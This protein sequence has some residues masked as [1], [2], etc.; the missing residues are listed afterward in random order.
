MGNKKKQKDKTHSK[1]VPNNFLSSFLG[2]F[3]LSVEKTLKKLP[4]SSQ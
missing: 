1:S 3:Q 4:Y 2:I